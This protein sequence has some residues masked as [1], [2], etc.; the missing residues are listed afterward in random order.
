[1]KSYWAVLA[2]G[3][4]T[5][6]MICAPALAQEAA[7]P[8]DQQGNTLSDIVVT[9]QRRSQSLQDVPVAVS[10]FTSADLTAKQIQT[11]LDIPRLVPNMVGTSNIGIGS[12]NTYFIRGL[13][14]TESIATFDPPVGTY[15]DDIYISRQNA[16]N[17]SFFD[18]E[19]IEVLRGP[20]GTLF[21]RNTTGGAINV[22]LKKPSPDL[23]G[24]VEGSYG[25]FD[26]V[27]GR[28]SIDIP[29]SDKLLT[30]F[31][32]FGVRRDGYIRNVTT[33]ERNNGESNYGFRGAVRAL[34]SDA[35]TWDISAD[36][37]R[38]NQ[39]NVPS[40]LVDDRLISHT[41]LSRRTAAL[42]GLVAGRK[43]GFHLQNITK[44]FSATSN[45]QID[46]GGPTI[47]LITGYRRLHQD[48]LTDVF[49][50]RFATGGFAIVNTG[51]FEQFSQEVK[52]TGQIAERLDYVAGLFYLHEDNRTDFA[53]VFTID[54]GTT[55]IPLVLSDRVLN[56]TTSAPAVYAQ[57]D[58][59]ATDAL[60]LTLGA[61][62]THEVKRVRVTPNSN[63]LLFGVPYGSADLSAA[64]IPLRQKVSLLTP[65]FAAEYRFN[66]DFML[67]ASATRGFRS[68]GWNARALS[69]ENFRV[70]GPEKVW[71]YE[72]GLRSELLDKRLRLNITGFYTD[73]N[74]FQVPLGFVDS[75]GAINFV[76]QNGSDFRNYGIE[77]EAEFV[78]AAGATIFANFGTQRA[79]YLN[80]DA[81]IRAQ[82]AA[83]RAGDAAS[84]GQGIVAPNGSLAIPE[85]TP[86]FTAAFGGTYELPIGTFL[87]T[88][89]ANASYQSRQTV[90]TAAVPG[91]FVGPDWL[92][93]ASLTF[94]PADGPWHV[95]IECSNCFNNH[96]VGTN[97]PPGLTF[98]NEPMV[99]RVT[100]G[101]DF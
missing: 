69:A 59:H 96:F 72:T 90:G 80:P 85:R 93:G 13:G 30:K 79:K 76:T 22:I 34:P 28:A 95:G 67:F 27:R 71:S 29:L 5:A 26:E 23:G 63:P 18:V 60:T 38:G 7:A 89:S 83:C 66:P 12:A 11:T 3:A 88:P 45:L 32:A 57:A 84:C 39:V 25:R 61:R 70:F 94:R 44:S 49:D 46:T 48:Y 19:R 74:G 78:P 8:S 51:R 58:W 2:C 77:A 64:G 82:Q 92:V 6:S 97:F 40:V 87:L 98:Y 73:V 52:L 1:M 20:Q 9:A 65:R 56:N 14:N 4:A 42:E 54:A 24:Y 36:Y 75:T 31:S 53:D 47:N 86:K 21:G 101:F 99:W 81:A 10:A 35:V 55:G 15:V 62:Y 50:G 33:G 37:I 41:G 100:A 43:A 91:D 17:F 68:G 16:N